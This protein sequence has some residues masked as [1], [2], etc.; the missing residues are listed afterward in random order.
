MYLACTGFYQVT[1]AADAMIVGWSL[2]GQ[3]ALEATQVL[4]Q[5]AGYGLRPS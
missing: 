1:D 4:P 3:I 2:G 5:A